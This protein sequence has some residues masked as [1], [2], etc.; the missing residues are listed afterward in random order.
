MQEEETAAYV[1]LWA[2]ARER[3]VLWVERRLLLWSLG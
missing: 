2:A 3:K 1:N